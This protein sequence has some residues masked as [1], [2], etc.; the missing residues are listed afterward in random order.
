[1]PV[2]SANAENIPS[3][4]AE[5]FVENLIYAARWLLAPIY[6]GLS[7]ALVALGLKFFL[8]RMFMNTQQVPNDKLMWY[9]II[10]LTFVMSAFV[11]SNM[12]KRDKR[13]MQNDAM[14]MQRA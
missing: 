6:F 3:K 9:V 14:R 13:A 10:H 5:R 12:D 1:M 2:Q 7:L 4:P 11:M 8:L